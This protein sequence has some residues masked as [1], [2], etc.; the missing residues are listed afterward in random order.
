MAVADWS[1][2]QE[3]KSIVNSIEAALHQV[4]RLLH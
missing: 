3:P 2:W 4:Q 1:L